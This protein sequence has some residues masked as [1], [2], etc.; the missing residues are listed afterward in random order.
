VREAVEKGEIA[1]RR[2]ESYLRIR[3]SLLEPR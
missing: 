3:G 1:A 2:Y